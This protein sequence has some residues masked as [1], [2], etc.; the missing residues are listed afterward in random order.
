MEIVFLQTADADVYREILDA[1]AVANILFCRRHKIKYESYVGVKLGAAPWMA[2]YNRIF[3][4]AEL[5]D[6]GYSGWAIFLDADAFVADL[7]FNIKHYLADN[8]EYCLVGTTGGSTTPWDINS[9]VLFINLGDPDGQTFIR[10]WK[11]QFYAKVPPTYLN[12]GQ[13]AWDEYP[14]DQDLMYECLKDNAD[15]LRKTKRED[16]S[17]FNYTDG[18]IIRQALRASFLTLQGR[19]NWVREQVG[20]VLGSTAVAEQYL[21]LTAIANKYGCD[22]GDWS[23]NAQH[24]TQYY[25][26]LF[27][28]FRL[29]P[30]EC[31]E[32]GLLQGGPESGGSVDRYVNDAP[33]IRMWLDFFPNATCHGVDIS[34]FSSLTLQRFQFHRCDVGSLTDVA[35]LRDRLPRLKFIIDDASHASYH[36]QVAFAALFPLVEPGGYYIIENVHWQPDY[37]VK[38]PT[39]VRTRDLFLKFTRSRSLDMQ[40]LPHADQVLLASQIMRTQFVRSREDGCTIKMVVLQK[41]R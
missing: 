36:Q 38:L 28:E 34:D 40:F 16:V 29:E 5:L 37:E 7:D 41:L 2:S 10:E 18:R 23:A 31:L 27:E 1:S 15:L 22:K 3:M 8:Q 30:L 35:Q 32:I 33:S 39:C 19:T 17:K 11:K 24:Y 20:I 6:R 13:S 12:N 9:G 21:N 14:N 26:F 4:L 25:Q